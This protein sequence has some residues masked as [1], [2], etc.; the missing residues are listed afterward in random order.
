MA[1]IP[2]KY[3]QKLGGSIG[4][5]LSKL[6]KRRYRISK[7]NISLTG[8]PDGTLDAHWRALGISLFETANALF[9]PSSKIADQLTIKNMNIVDSLMAKGQNIMLLVPHTTHMLLAGRALL[10]V[11]KTNNIYRPQNNKAFNYYLTKSYS[12]HGA[13]LI[14]SSDVRE[15]IKSIK[16]GTPL[17]YAPDNDLRS[18]SVF[19]SFFGI[20][21]STLIATKKLS[22][23][24]NASIVPLSFIRKNGEYCLSFNEPFKL[25]NLSEQAAADKVNYELEKLIDKVPEQYYW[26]HRRFKTTPDNI[27]VYK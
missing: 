2:H 8:Q 16:S 17:W 5:F 13:N 1:K 23:M 15:I 6:L 11:F 9:A 18:K 26:V 4:L 27:D 7:I 20:Q 25:D 24:A 3:Q 14:D 19:S 10:T 12:D 21:A 22:D